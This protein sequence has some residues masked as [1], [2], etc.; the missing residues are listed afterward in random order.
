M[1]L[2]QDSQ[3]PSFSQVG[4]GSG[5]NR[6]TPYTANVTSVTSNVPPG[7]LALAI[8]TNSPPAK[9]RIGLPK[10][11]YTY[12]LVEDG[13]YK[14]CRGS[15]EAEGTQILWLRKWLG[16]WVAFDGPDVADSPPVG[17]ADQVIFKSS[18]NIL[19]AGDHKWRMERSKGKE[20]SFETTLLS[21]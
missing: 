14:C 13:V 9:L 2:T 21:V 1:D 15:D 5:A 18:E 11:D 8:P 20:G 17:Q 19:V 4:Q 7:A 3:E 10:Y 12:T 16:D 6:P